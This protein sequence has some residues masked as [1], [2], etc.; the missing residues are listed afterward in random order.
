MISMIS[1]ISMVSIISMISMILSVFSFPFVGAYLQ[2]FSGHFYISTDKYNTTNIWYNYSMKKYHVVLNTHVQDF[3]VLVKVMIILF[4][5]IDHCRLVT[6][7]RSGQSLFSA[8][9]S[10]QTCPWWRKLRWALTRPLWRRSS[11]WGWCNCQ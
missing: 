2:S 7:C 5:T 6:S 11:R 8:R 4:I 3:P 1:M 9:G 10:D